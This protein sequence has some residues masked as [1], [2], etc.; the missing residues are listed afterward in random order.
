MSQ[1]SNAQPTLLD[2]N[3]IAKLLFVGTRTVW[4]LEQADP[5]FPKR[6][7]ISR[8]IIRWKADE[9]RNYIEMR[10]AQPRVAVSA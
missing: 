6:V 2:V 7:Q 10:A 4:R 1:T 9:I 3:A 5:H 8:G